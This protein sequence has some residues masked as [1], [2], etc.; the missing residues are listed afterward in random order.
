VW[1]VWISLLILEKF[2]DK[3][4]RKS[5]SYL[6][7]NPA[8]RMFKVLARNAILPREEPFYSLLT[9]LNSP[10]IVFVNEAVK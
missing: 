3:I 9:P 10:D 7:E 8:D 5:I 1:N 6:E 2:E 4:L